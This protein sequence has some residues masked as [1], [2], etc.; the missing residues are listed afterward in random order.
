MLLTKLKSRNLIHCPEWLPENT[1]YITIM[2]SQAYGVNKDDSDCDI[3]GFV[4]PPKT[5]IFP[6]LKGEINGF[7]KQKQRFDCWQEHHVE[8]KDANKQYDFQIY[9][10]V[11]YFHL[12]MENNP[13]MIDSLFT[14][15]NCVIHS[16]QISELIRSQ[17]RMFLHKG[18]YHKF[19]GYSYSQVHKLCTKNPEG[20][21]K[22]DIELNGIDTKYAYHLVRLLNEAEQ[23]LVEGDLDLQKNNE[24][25]KSIRRGEW[26][27]EQ[28]LQYFT[29]KEKCLEIA[30]ANSKLPHKPNE[31]KI[32]ELLI[33][34]LEIHYGS[35]EKAIVIEGRFE[36]AID[37]I[38]N[39]CAA[40]N[41][42]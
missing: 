31:E 32:K 23:I 34:C 9:S 35:L 15:A 13:N 2:G 20:K 41:K 22:D 27:Q 33:N 14:P 3:Y 40:L 19:K 1:S 42:K 30:Y 28:V 36:R 12:C 26:S 24:Q 38:Y 29:D 8:D 6:H 10:I 5:D 4:I 18:S 16:T 11:R 37:D 7:G 21:R 39:I 17:R 25:L